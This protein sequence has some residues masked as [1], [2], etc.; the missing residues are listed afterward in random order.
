[1]VSSIARARAVS[2]LTPADIRRAC[3]ISVRSSQRWAQRR[4]IPHPPL[5][6]GAS[7]AGGRRVPV[8]TVRQPDGA[9]TTS[10]TAADA[11]RPHRSGIRAQ[12]GQADSRMPRLRDRFD[13]LQVDS[14]SGDNP[15]D[16]V[17]IGRFDR[18]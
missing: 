2:S 17:G 11:R 3:G 6:C 13:S 7:R 12:T 4:A 14:G 15:L 5:V 1:V 10:A 8:V 18:L 16:S 9:N